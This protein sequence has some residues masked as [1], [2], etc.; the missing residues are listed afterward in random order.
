MSKVYKQFLPVMFLSLGTSTNNAGPVQNLE[1]FITHGDVT[2]RHSCD[3]IFSTNPIKVR[4][5]KIIAPK[6]NKV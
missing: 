5:R 1:K 2:V 4:D 6:A 3:C